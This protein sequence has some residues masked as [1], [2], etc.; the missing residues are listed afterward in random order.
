MTKKCL[1]QWS[2]RKEVWKYVCV[3]CPLLTCIKDKPGVVSSRENLLLS[4]RETELRDKVWSPERS[5]WVKK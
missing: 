3:A 4:I 1:L 2:K 5:E